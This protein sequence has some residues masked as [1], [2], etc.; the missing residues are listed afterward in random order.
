MQHCAELSALVSSSV[1]SKEKCIE[2]FKY[3]YTGVLDTKF[4][5]NFTRTD[6]FVMINN[7]NSMIK[8]DI[9]E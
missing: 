7:R 9:F 6:G 2:N 8:N 3:R 1:F 5:Q 4:F